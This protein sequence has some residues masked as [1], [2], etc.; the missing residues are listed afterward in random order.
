M[1]NLLDRTV[2]RIDAIQ[3]SHRWTAFPVAVLKKFGDDRGTRLAALVAYYGLFS[4]FPLLLILTT[5]LGFLLSGNQELQAQVVR[6]IV[7]QF[8]LLEDE[9]RQSVGS[10]S[11]SGLG[12]LVGIGGLLWAGM[13]VMATLQDAMN[14]VW[15]V[16]IRVRPN[17]FEKR[18]RALVMLAVLGVGFL[19][20]AGL[21]MFTALGGLGAASVGGYLLALTFD[22]AVFLL[23]FRLLTDRDMP[24]G[25]FVPGAC[26]GAFGWLLLQSL[27]GIYVGRALAGATA[28][29]G[30]FAA[31]IGL[32]S[33]MYLLAQWVLLAAEVNVVHHEHLWPRTFF[34]NELREPADREALRRYAEVQERREEQTVWTFFQSDPGSTADRNPEGTSST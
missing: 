12:L 16:P 6:S 14:T 17:F 7:E 33:W 25:T 5:S 34:G 30:F 8:P 26:V 31:V 11:G 24:W 32:L 3:R 27:G 4:L 2:T 10:F 1:P 20:A 13:G 22:F 15:D 18:L 23:A 19:V 29:Y 9:I 28:T 21:A